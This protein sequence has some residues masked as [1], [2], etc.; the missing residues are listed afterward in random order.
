M[1]VVQECMVMVMVSL[2]QTKQASQMEETKNIQ[3]S[4]MFVRC[5]KLPWRIYIKTTCHQVLDDEG[6]NYKS[7]MT[8]LLSKLAFV[9]PLFRVLLA[10]GWRWRRRK[11]LPV[12][13]VLEKENGAVLS[14]KHFCQDN[15]MSTSLQASKLC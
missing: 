12:V 15:Q 14:L 3:E 13:K 11:S 8:R 5:I 9:K 2:R 10:Q 1:Y 7:W 4:K 6:D